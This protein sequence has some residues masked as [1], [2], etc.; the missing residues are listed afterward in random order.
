MKSPHENVVK[1]CQFAQKGW[2]LW[3]K[4]ATQAEY[5][6]R[7][8][9]EQIDWMVSFYNRYHAN[10]RISSDDIDELVSRFLNSQSHK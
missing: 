1:F 7:C 5:G 2:A 9:R 10:D 4:N 8:V 3:F 6:K